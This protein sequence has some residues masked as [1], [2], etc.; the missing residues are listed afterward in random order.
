MLLLRKIILLVGDI[1]ILYISLAL[2]LII[3]YGTL[4]VGESFRTHLFPFSLIFIVWILSLTLFD[5]YH[6][7]TSANARFLLR[8]LF[9]A[10]ITA[11]TLSTILFYLFT[12]FFELTP[13]TNLFILTAVFLVLAYGWRWGAKQIFTSGATPIIILGN[14][15]LITEANE[16]ITSHPHFGYRVEAWI[17]SPNESDATKLA[18]TIRSKRVAL[19]ITQPGLGNNFSMLQT[20]LSLFPLGVAFMNFLDFYELIFEKVPI[21]D[22]NEAWFI[23]NISTRRRMYDYTKRIVDFVFSLLLSIVLLPIG[24]LIGLL[25]LLTSTGNV[26]Y[27]QKRAGRNGVPFMLYK[28]RTMRVNVRGTLWTEKNDERITPIGRFLRAAHLDELPQLW[29]ILL[30]D[31]SFTGPRP[32]RTE[33]AQQY[34][35][36]PYYD[37][38][39]II[40]PGLSGWAQI[41]YKPSSSLDEAYEKL[42]YDLY[43]VRNRSILLDFIIVLKTIKYIFIRHS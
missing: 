31:I 34:N 8:E 36:L 37:M 21:K 16:Y 14:S 17:R 38:R 11:A 24:I 20:M 33:L 27:T 22:L 5:L 9:V 23:E 7:K 30:G 28:F 12:S 40:K 6:P 1:L 13:K 43:Y 35:S 42:Q 10:T 19:V 4:H 32:E 29:N 26:L 3:R 39:H 15:P 2:T 18:T 25:V 41:N